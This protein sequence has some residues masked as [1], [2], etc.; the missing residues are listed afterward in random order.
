MSSANE[1]V[2]EPYSSQKR[3]KMGS[4]ARALLLAIARLMTL[5]DM[6]D[7]YSAG[8][9]VDFM[10]KNL[11]KMK[12]ARNQKDFLALFHEYG[13]Y[14]RDLLN[15]MPSILQVIFFLSL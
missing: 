5:V 8:S 9:L 14:L 2:K 13:Q 15:I 3:A 11:G 12:L 10:L 4:Q 1:F 6:I 7:S